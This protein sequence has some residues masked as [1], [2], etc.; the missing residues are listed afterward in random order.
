MRTS[1][2]SLQC[3]SVPKRTWRTE[4]E[5]SPEI[6]KVTAAEGLWNDDEKAEDQQREEAEETEALEGNRAIPMDHLYFVKPLKSKSGKHVKMAIQEIVLQLRHENLP[7]VRIHSDRAH[8]MRSVALR[9]WALNN[10]ILLTRTEGQSP[11]GNGA[12]ERAVR[13]FE[14]AGQEATTCSGDGHSFL[15]NSNVD[16]SAS[17]T[18][19]R[20]AT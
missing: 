12:A 4:E 10:N 7:V 9:E 18:R 13:F 20:F 11:Q 6:F 3:Y 8:E 1:S 17:S 14:G 5:A 16:G 15:G 19:K 2:W